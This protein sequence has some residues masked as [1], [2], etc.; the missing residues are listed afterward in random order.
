MPKTSKDDT[1]R[2]V[3]DQ[4]GTP[5]DWFSRDVTQNMIS[6]CLSSS[7]LT[8][9]VSGHRQSGVSRDTGRRRCKDKTAFAQSS[10]EHLSSVHCISY[11]IKV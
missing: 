11:I 5:E 2:F 4:V 7:T 6:S 9:Y 3:F 10:P 8:V 1:A